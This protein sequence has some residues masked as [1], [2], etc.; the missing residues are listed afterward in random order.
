VNPEQ[1]QAIAVA[2]GE[3][4]VARGDGRGP[5]RLERMLYAPALA[6]WI[7]IGYFCTVVIGLFRARPSPERDLYLS[8]VSA[9]LSA[10]VA[11]VYIFRLRFEAR[12][13]KRA[14]P[15]TVLLAYHILPLI[16]VL[17]FYFNLRP[18]LPLIN[19]A[20]YDSVLYRL[21]LAIFGL[22]PTLA[23]EQFSTP[24]V[25]E[26]FAFFYY[27][28]FFVIASFIFVMIFTC[29]SDERL[30]S[31]AT[32]VLLIVAVGHYVYTLVPGLG[33]YAHLAHEYRA[34]LQ[35]GPFYFLVLDAVSRAGP[36]R[37]IFPSLHTALPT[38]CSLFAWRHYPRIAPIVTVFAA[39]IIGATIVLR[40]HYAI[41]VLAGL[42]LAVTAFI[43]APRLVDA[44]QSRR[45][46]V[47]L[48]FRRW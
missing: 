30:A 28:Y 4:V 6:D 42:L 25:V 33:P 12:H 3:D 20:T 19:S 15:Y 34:P 38:F 45:E 21:D 22:E 13:G 24:R 8:M 37:D 47:G 23:A 40:W 2:E 43:A 36:M 35:G 44:Y 9:I 17:A 39:N 7:V 27:S 14:L 41:D 18:I 1:G 31:F 46:S 26:W 32:G 11:G 29:E 5:T 16:A 10:F 48:A